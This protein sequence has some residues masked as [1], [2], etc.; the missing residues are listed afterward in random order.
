MGQNSFLKLQVGNFR[1]RSKCRITVSAKEW[2]LALS[3]TFESQLYRH[4]RIEREISFILVYNSSRL[5]TY[6]RPS[7][8]RSKNI[9]T[10]L[11]SS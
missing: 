1:G 5:R 4:I 3:R 6:W 11:T 8:K 2:A 10:H 9:N 7:V